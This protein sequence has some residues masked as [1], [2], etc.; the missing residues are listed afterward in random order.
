MAHKRIAH[1]TDWFGIV[2]PLLISF[3]LAV[4][5]I[6]NESP[7]VL[8][9]AWLGVGVA[10]AWSLVK[11][12]DRFSWALWKKTI[13][14]GVAMAIVFCA[15]YWNITE[16]LRPSFVFVTPGPLFNGDTWDFIVNHRG[17]K[18]NY[19]V[20][21]L[22]VDDD[23]LEYLQRTTQSV[24]SQDMNSFQLLLPLSEVNPKGRGTIFA[25]QFQWKPFSL[26]NSHFTA[27]ITWRDGAAHEEI[28]IAR[29]QDN[30]KYAIFLSDKESGK[31]LFHCKD[32]GFPSAESLPVCFPGINDS[33]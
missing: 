4:P 13:P 8:I 31:S 9:F 21:I 11:L 6:N 1:T 19:N 26:G 18:T 10:F 28:R 16:R 25:R 7:T 33:D 20:Q 17:S 14:I 22:F 5:I 24:T 32:D 27:E 15:A 23:R 30:W 2:F 12:L 29:V 3:A